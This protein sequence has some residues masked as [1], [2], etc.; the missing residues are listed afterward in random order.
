MKACQTF[1]SMTQLEIRDFIVPLF[2]SLFIVECCV[3]FAKKMHCLFFSLKSNC[4]L[5]CSNLTF[6]SFEIRVVEKVS[7]LIN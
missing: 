1:L 2:Y 6:F 7:T 4:R 5:C 3:V